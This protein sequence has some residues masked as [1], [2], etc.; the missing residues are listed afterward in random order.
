MLS[1]FLSLD[2]DSKRLVLQITYEMLGLNSKLDFDEA[3]SLFAD[4]Y[5]YNEEGKKQ[6]RYWMNFSSLSS[7]TKLMINIASTIVMMKLNLISQDTVHFIFPEKCLHAKC[8]SQF[9]KFLG[10][11]VGNGY[12]DNFSYYPKRDY[13]ILI[14]TYSE[15]MLNG[16]RINI[17]ECS[18]KST[19]YNFI[20]NYISNIFQPISLYLTE[21]E[22]S[23][24]DFDNYP[25]GFQDQHSID[26]NELLK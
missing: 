19:K 9:G 3:T 20:L 26:L 12:I 15:H 6:N 7:G 11:I 4:A 18:K 23:A 21:T 13:Q 1:K 14:T 8:Q 10:R 24:V 22:F 16:M 25:A 5:M 17:K 2:L